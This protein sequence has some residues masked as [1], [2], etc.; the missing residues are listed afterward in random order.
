MSITRDY[1]EAFFDALMTREPDRIAPY[2]AD[3]A[4]WLIIGPTEL[5]RYCGQH[6]GKAAVLEAYGWML[7]RNAI[8]YF[9]RDFLVTDGASASALT[10][11]IDVQRGSGRS[12]TIRLAQFARFRDGKVHEFCSI[13]DTLGA[14]EQV[15]GRSLIDLPD[16]PALSEV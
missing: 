16:V 1:A 7:K 6:N 9:E 3:D 5:F 8:S 13:T 4:D 14:A 12:L 15:M 11:L 10:S 2:V